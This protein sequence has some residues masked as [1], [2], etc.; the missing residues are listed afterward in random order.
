MNKYYVYGHFYKES[1]IPFYIGKG[2]ANRLNAT[3]N[4]SRAWKD[5]VKNN[6]WY[7]RK[8]KEN[9]TEA[10]ALELES[11]LILTTDKLVNTKHINSVIQ[12]L[13]GEDFRDILEYSASSPTG[14]IWKKDIYSGFG[15][16]L[17]KKGDCAGSPSAKSPSRSRSF[18]IALT[19]ESGVC[20]Q[21]HTHRVIWALCYGSITSE[22]IVDHIDGNPFNNNIENLRVVSKAVNTRNRKLLRNNKVGVNGVKM[23]IRGAGNPV[24]VATCYLEGKQL[25]RY[26]SVKDYGLLPAFA[27][28]I[29]WRQT[30]IKELN[31][32]GAGYTNRHGT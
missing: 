21:Y 29:Q 23:I 22:Q 16:V 7:S 28:A 17:R 13:Y 20:K 26:F 1:N 24:Y 14:L 19:T 5:V 10:E 18:R 3:S 32:Q 8:I 2:S 31:E 25:Q 4:R 15:G 12:T 27:L 9:L 6:E 11:H 30:K